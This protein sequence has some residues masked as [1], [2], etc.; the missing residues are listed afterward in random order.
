MLRRLLGYSMAT[1]AIGY[2][3]PPLPPGA[4]IEAVT[5]E[6][7]VNPHIPMETFG[8]AEMQKA[9]ADD[10]LGT[11]LAEDMLPEVNRNDAST[12]T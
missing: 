7:A 12:V 6:Y 8:G 9:M 3:S 2:Y 5:S 10:I 11:D 4:G 1:Y